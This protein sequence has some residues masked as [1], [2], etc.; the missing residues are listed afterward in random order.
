MVS[1]DKDNL[2]YLW[3]SDYGS[4]SVCDSYDSTFEYEAVAT[5]EKAGEFVYAYNPEHTLKKEEVT[6]KQLE[7][8]FKTSY[9]VKDENECKDLDLEKEIQDI[10]N[11][12]I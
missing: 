10:L 8:W 12:L 5:Q 2:I 1:K 7:E 3:R 11:N 9:E 4:C 6:H